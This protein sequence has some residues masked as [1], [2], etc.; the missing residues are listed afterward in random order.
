MD[1][2]GRL[3]GYAAVSLSSLPLLQPPSPYRPPNSA[4]NPRCGSCPVNGGRAWQLDHVDNGRDQEDAGCKHQDFSNVEAGKEEHSS[5]GYPQSSTR[6]RE[7]CA[8][9][10]AAKIRTWN[11][12]ARLLSADR[13]DPKSLGKRAERPAPLPSPQRLLPPPAHMRKND[14]GLWEQEPQGYGAR[15]R[16]DQE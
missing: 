4:T 16:E 5:H 9:G 12:D 2:A 14:F 1:S 3:R 15:T 7:D 11:P 13:I 10:T 6:H 8:I